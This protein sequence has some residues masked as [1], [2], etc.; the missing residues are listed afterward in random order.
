MR[1]QRRRQR[2][3]SNRLAMVRVVQ[4][5]LNHC[6]DAWDL[7]Q[8]FVR[9][10]CVSIALL[11]D[12]YTTRSPGW[13][14]DVA[15][16]A[17]VG[18]LSPG[19]TVG[20]IET[21]VGFVSVTVGCDLRVYSCYAPPRWSDNEF[22]DFLGRLDDSVRSRATTVSR[23]IVGGDFNA[24]S[25]SWGSRCSNRRGETLCAFADSLG[26]VVA[27]RG[28]EPTF[29]GRGQG[30][31]VDVTFASEAA[32][33]G[34]NDWTVRTDVENG[35]DHHYL[36]YSVG[37]SRTPVARDARS[38][39]DGPSGSARHLGWHT[40]ELDADSLAAGLLLAEWVDSSRPPENVAAADP[41]E[42]E[43]DAVVRHAT[44]ACDFSLRRR[45]PNASRRPPVYWWNGEIAAARAECV[46]SRRAMT[47][48]RA[49]G[50][51]DAT[52][53]VEGNLRTARAV[54]KRLIRAAKGKCWDEMIQ[55]VD[56]DPWGKPYK[57]VMKKLRGPSATS[58]MEP[59]LLREVVTSLFPDRPQRPV[60]EDGQAGDDGG[61][62][63]A[64]RE[65]SKAEVDA[66]VERFRRRNR[67]P[68][69]DGIP[70]RVWGVIHAARPAK[71]VSAFNCCLRNGT[72][73][74]R[75]KVAR[76]ALVP[77]PDKPEGLPSSYRPLCLLDDVGKVLEYLLV[78]RMEEHMTATGNE[79]S[80]RQFGFRGGRSTDDALRI[81]HE[82]VVGACNARR[83]AVV[84]SLD[85]QNAF[86][87]VGWDV[88]AAA[89]VRM[90]F[91]PYIR[92]IVGSYLSDRVLI[93]RDGQSDGPETAP[94]TCG[95][96]Q[97]SVLGPL[98]WNVA[99]D[100]VLRLPLP[101]GT[102]TI[103]YADDTLIVAEGDSVEAAQNRTNAALATVSRGIGD[104]GLQLAV[105]KTAAVA[106][107]D[108]VWITS[109]RIRLNGELVALQDSLKYLGILLDRKA[110]LY[111][112]HIRAAAEKAQRVLTSLSRLM[113]NV[114]GPGE[115][116]RR[117]LV[118]VVHSVLLYGAPTWG[119]HL[120]SIPGAVAEMA[121]VQR[122]AALRSVC[123][124]RTV[125][126]DA[127]AVV[128]STVPIDLLA[129]ER[130]QAFTA[131]RVVAQ[132]A[133]DAA[134]DRLRP[135]ALRPRTLTLD[136][137]KRRIRSSEV[138]EETGR[139][140][141]RV[142]IPPDMLERWTSRTHGSMSF[143]LT[144]LF[145]GHGCFNRF[146][147]RIGR[148]PSPGCSH[149]GFPDE[150]NEVDDDALHTLMRCEAFDG[151]RERLVQ[152]VGTFDPGGLVSLMLA[153]QDSWDAVSD[154]ARAVMSAK[155]SA[156]RI[157]QG[158]AVAVDGPQVR[159]Q[160]VGRR[161]R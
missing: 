50:D 135:P 72:F 151:E 68:G 57:L 45:V 111:G 73:P 64:G 21:G 41:S 138:P 91:P 89:L 62:L 154:F 88:I 100:A 29:H 115:K 77:K 35:S 136:R 17:L 124:Y 31:V 86:N 149:C 34:V 13:Y 130:C 78:R 20:D 51:T 156:E 132:R 158:Q 69:P 42:E 148:A 107:S 96:P 6:R 63:P 106:F 43:A 22:D 7:L 27:N 110:C 67:A 112:A 39:A 143:H 28:G 47:R 71:L 11:S 95:V 5:N 33:S 161:R 150:V 9:E 94:V 23:V 133:R 146:L 36:S 98:L 12:P 152:R 102:I 15:G 1:V 139:A 4:A 129:L 66:A 105:H 16:L 58:R 92:R 109:P 123:A 122:R 37:P 137:W 80:E 55:S 79:L 40:A 159:H 147:H 157:R 118:G 117:L 104:L 53:A 3:P 48:C 56:V 142:L 19:L 18:V 113:P 153:S 84:V 81:L 155:E 54:L 2:R 125:S 75:W 134:V 99:Y 8:Q 121:A 116:R 61:G 120:N 52:T 10:D 25:V 144:Q 60:G 140:W 30:S 76:L 24:W 97:G 82:K 103:G 128:A 126:Y 108:R 114:G 119:P 38:A 127:A 85:I 141:T 74:G 87:T 46:R 44:S 83:M 93:V 160:V 49:R 26:L 101:R 32:I 59:Q 131:K 145:T 70:S 90:G 14:P 65:F